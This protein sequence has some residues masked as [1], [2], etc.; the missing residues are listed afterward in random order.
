MEENKVL[1]E[2]D[3]AVAEVDAPAPMSD[4]ELKKA[5]NDTLERVRTQNMILGYRTVPHV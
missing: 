3:E 5:I 1:P 2:V 4:D